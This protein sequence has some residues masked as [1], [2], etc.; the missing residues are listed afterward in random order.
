MEN[1]TLSIRSLGRLNNLSNLKQN[2][3]KIENLTYL[4]ND[5]FPGHFLGNLHIN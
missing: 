5:N 2:G 3:W 4:S 1:L